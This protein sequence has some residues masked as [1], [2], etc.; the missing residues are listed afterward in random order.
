MNRMVFAAVM[1]AVA[2]AT[3]AGPAL[4]GDEVEVRVVESV[5][6]VPP[7]VNLTFPPASLPAPGSLLPD[8]GVR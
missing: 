8:R 5:G 7:A 3:L 6:A 4:A 1:L 2:L